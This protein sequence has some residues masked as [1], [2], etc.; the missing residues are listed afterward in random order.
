MNHF[1]DHAKIRHNNYFNA[2]TGLR[3]FAAL[4]V[5]MFHV[6]RYDSHIPIKIFQF[7]ITDAFGM[8]WIGVHIFFVLSGFL[9][10]IP[11]IKWINNEK[12]YPQL[13]SYY[14][15]RLLRV[16]PA[17]YTQLLILIILSYTIGYGTKLDITEFVLHLFMLF[18]VE[19]WFINPMADFWW[20]LPT[21]LSFYLTLP[22]IAVVFKKYGFFT[23][24]LS[25]I[26]ATVLFRYAI[27]QSIGDQEASMVIK[28]VERFPGHITLFV[29]GMLA[30]YIYQIKPMISQKASSF[31]LLVGLIWVYFCIQWILDVAVIKGLYY[32]G[33]YSYFIWN[34]I[35][36][37]GLA[38][39]IYSCAAK[40]WLTEIIFSNRVVVFL[41]IIS[42]SIYLWHLPVIRLTKQYIYPNLQENIA[43]TLMVTCIPIIIVV[44]AL[45]YKLV[46]AP[47]IKLGAK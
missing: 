19:P 12:P 43:I 38:F 16:F 28:K 35:N 14:K 25:A 24:L 13:K 31:L 42:Y 47:C 22:I 45:S 9:L 33:H 4:W 23:I 39:I 3:G 30:A 40:N 18:R 41:G 44:A 27:F 32:K 8:G 37:I 1:Q 34:S 36:A 21:E 6:R 46:E 2:L 11:F 29:F 10:S 20:T 17:Y 15:R 26:V 5:F 7:N